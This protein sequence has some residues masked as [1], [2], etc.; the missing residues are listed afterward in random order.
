MSESKINCLNTPI[1]NPH[2]DAK[3][4][5]VLS[6]NE[7]ENAIAYIYLFEDLKNIDEGFIDENIDRLPPERK[8]RCLRYRNK[9]DKA[10]CIL[11]Y[12]L[13]S[14]M[15]LEQ[16]NIDT[17]PNFT[18][19]EHSKPYLKDTDNLFFSIS[20][21]KNAVAVVV[22]DFEIGLD[23]ET[24]REVNE[25]IIDK[26]CTEKE[27]IFLADSCDR[28]R[29]FYRLWTMKESYTKAYGR[30]VADVL[31]KDLE[32]KDFAFYSTD[33][34]YL[35]VYCGRYLEKHSNIVNRLTPENI[36]MFTIIE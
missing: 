8:E 23:I 14:K 13:L 7:K 27:K 16:Y 11:A 17:V 3:L 25:N 28:V 31:K 21:T 33:E 12:M 10:A 22:T 29:D 26:V 18:Y 15:L 9:S 36:N 19:N 35:N 4:L 34:F 32:F 30:T 2:N 24:I 20:H 1:Q 6:D 5:K